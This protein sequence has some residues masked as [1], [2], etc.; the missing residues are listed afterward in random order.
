MEKVYCVY[1]IHEESHIDPFSEGY[2]G[3][4]ANFE[5]RIKRYKQKGQK[6]H[7]YDKFVS[8]AKVSILAKNLLE[9]EALLLEKKLRPKRN[10]GWNFNSGGFFPPIPEK[11]K[12]GKL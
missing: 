6:S 3:I 11:L 7:L 1:W 4:S 10:I 12:I 5:Y 9:F 8:G 2:I